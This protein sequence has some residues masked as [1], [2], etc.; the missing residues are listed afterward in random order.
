[1]HDSYTYLSFLS[2]ITPASLGEKLRSEADEGWG[3][4]VVS[5]QLDPG[6][7]ASFRPCYINVLYPRTQTALGLMS[8]S[9]CFLT[10]NHCVCPLVLEYSE[11]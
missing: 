6:F 9:M 8:S 1:M 2:L 4:N 11:A 5:L 3:R 10:S 7:K